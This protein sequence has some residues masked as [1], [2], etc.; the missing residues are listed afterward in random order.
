MGITNFHLEDDNISFKPLRFEA[1]LDGI[2]DAK[3]DIQWDTP[4]G[5]RADS[6]NYRIV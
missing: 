4:N 3:M 6:L 5:I 2:I 1:I